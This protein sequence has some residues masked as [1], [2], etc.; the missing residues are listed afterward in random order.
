MKF[1]SPVENEGIRMNKKQLNLHLYTNRN[2]NLHCVHCYNN[3]FYEEGKKEIETDQLL[4]LIHAVNDA[5]D[6]DVHLEGGEIFLR[7]EVFEAL[8]TLKEDVLKHITITSNGTIL[9]TSQ[10]TVYVIKNIGAFRISIEGHTNELNRIIRD[11]DAD[12]ILYNASIYRDMGVNVVLRTTLHKENYKIIMK[13]MIPAFVAKK[14][15]QMQIYELQAVGRGKSLD[16]MLLSD[17]EFNEFLNSMVET[18]LKD[19]NAKFMFN[20]HRVKQIENRRKELLDNGYKVTIMKSERSLSISTEGDVYICPWNMGEQI[21]FNVNDVQD[22]C[23]E[24]E[25]YDLV[26]ECEY[27]SKIKIEVG[28]FC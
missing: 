12:R 10:D 18:K 8:A 19:V 28:K 22:V 16:K 1:T 5:Y 13:E 15:Y 6:V 26:H 4:D 23:E 24:L 17:E 20:P 9:D 27:C 3:S 7:K 25:K 11:V 14:N 2:C 21:L